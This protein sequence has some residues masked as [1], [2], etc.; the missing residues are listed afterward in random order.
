MKRPL[1]N[2]KEGVSMKVCI[3]G[4]GYIGL[5]T[6]GILAD[7]GFNVVGVDVNEEYLNKLINR[8]FRT[9]ER[10]LIELIN[11]NL[12]SSSLRFSNKAVKADVFIIC[13]PTPL[14]DDKSVDLSYLLSALNSILDLIERDNLIIIESTIPPGTTN[15]IIKPLLEGQGLKVGV[16]IFLAY[17]PERVM[18]TN[19]IYELT[20]NSRVIGGSTKKCEDKTKSFYQSFVKGEIITE[21]VDI[22]ELIK[23]IENSY[24]DV[25]IAFANELSLL[26][27]KL[28]LDVYKVI[29]LANKHPRVN[30]LNPGIGVGGHCLPVDSY[31][32]STVHSDYTKIISISREINDN[33]PKIITEKIIKILNNFDNPVVALWGLAYK[34]NS[35]D[36][37]NSPA[38]EIL[39]LLRNKNTVVR[40]FDPVVYN[41]D[42]NFGVETLKDANLLMIL[43]NHNEFVEF[44]YNKYIS[45]MKTKIIFDG[46]NLIDK[47]TLDDGIKIIKLFKED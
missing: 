10:N 13:T 45:L 44:N 11:K 22:V 6:A 27:S 26:C 39:N 37:R 5:P 8:E 18:P 1:I 3:L 32:I 21:N 4:V 42:M 12:D 19:I 40:V 29:E 28:N 7:K 43:V 31:F 23:I 35:N 36:I 16:D 24:R 17:C 41:Q 46:V 20:N 34:G 25:N 47:S 14:K 33:M 15:N 2:S 38:V 9:N 30:I